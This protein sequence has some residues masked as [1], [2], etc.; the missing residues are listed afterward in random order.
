MMVKNME[1]II[2][3]FLDKKIRVYLPVSDPINY[4]T[5][6]LNEYDSDGLLMGC[7]GM[8][9]YTAINQVISMEA[10]K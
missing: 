7:Y 2:E 6:V 1:N 8:S 3:K 4:Y 9:V 10:L 5:G